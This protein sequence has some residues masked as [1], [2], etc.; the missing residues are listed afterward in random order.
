MLLLFGNFS[1]SVSSRVRNVE[2]GRKS[3]K[4][5][6]QRQAGKASMPACSLPGDPLLLL[7]PA[8]LYSQLS[9]LR[10]VPSESSGKLGLRIP[11]VA[12]S[13]APSNLSQYTTFLGS[14]P[15]SLFCFPSW[16]LKCSCCH[17]SLS[18]TSECE[19]DVKS[20][21]CW[22]HKIKGKR[23]PWVSRNFLQVLNFPPL[24]FLGSIFLK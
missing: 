10:L 21:R 17:W 15:H 11:T 18:S 7:L 13:C 19:V 4:S 1:E 12:H 20:C 23:M 6:F 24:Y 8:P 5:T 2:W 3:E 22:N 16:W 14:F 9:D